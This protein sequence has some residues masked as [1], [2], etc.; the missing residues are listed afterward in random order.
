VSLTIISRAEE[1]VTVVTW[2]AGSGP[3]ALYSG[4]G[5]AAVT[6]PGGSQ[7]L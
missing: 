6:P 2:G 4:V 1:E 5:K 3:T 7:W